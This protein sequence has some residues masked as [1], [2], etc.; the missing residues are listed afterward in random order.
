MTY[1]KLIRIVGNRYT[2]RTDLITDFRTIFS[3]L[4]E[5]NTIFIL[6]IEYGDVIYTIDIGKLICTYPSLYDSND[7]NDFIRKL[8]AEMIYTFRSDFFNNIRMVRTFMSHDLPGITTISPCNM[9]TGETSNT[10]YNPNYSDAVIWC[11]EYNLN[12]VIPVL[13]GKL[14]YPIWSQDKIYLENRVDL[15]KSTNLMTFVS[16]ADVDVEVLRL[17]DIRDNDWKIPNDKIPMLVLCGVFLYDVNNL[18]HVVNHSNS[19]ILHDHHIIQYLKNADFTVIEDIITDEDSFVIMVDCKRVFIRNTMLIPVRH[20]EQD[21]NEFVYYEDTP[22]E[23]HV[24]YVCVDNFNNKICGIS[25]ADDMYKNVITTEYSNEHH[26]YA[27]GGSGNL[28]LIQLA[29]C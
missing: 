22:Q 15:V 20:N 2:I 10:T 7:V 12:K 1:K 4:N 29:F 11:N 9:T 25:I 28:R 14:R 26:I 5:V 3:N 18:Y 8:N 13:G 24:D 6:M 21:V 17:R 16:F 19:L 27:H 23:H